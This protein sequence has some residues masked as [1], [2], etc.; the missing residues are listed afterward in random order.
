LFSWI[1]LSSFFGNNFDKLYQ[2]FVLKQ[3]QLLNK[4]ITTVDLYKAWGPWKNRRRYD[5]VKNL[6]I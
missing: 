1:N 5:P 6:Q 2:W 4:R 3:Y